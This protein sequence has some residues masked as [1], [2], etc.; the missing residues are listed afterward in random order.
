MKVIKR[1]N[2]LPLFDHLFDGFFRDEPMHWMNRE[3]K[4]AHSQAVNILEDEN[5][6]TIELMAPGFRKSDLHIEVEENV[7]KLSAK[8]EEQKE[9]EDRNYLRKEFRLNS[10]E[11]EFRLPENRIDE[12]KISARFED[13]ILLVALPK[14]EEVKKASRLI[15]VH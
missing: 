5:G 9:S 14:K 4:S 6:F 7:L 2:D 13:G 10:I 3:T 11:R 15:E 8:R 12:E 1:T